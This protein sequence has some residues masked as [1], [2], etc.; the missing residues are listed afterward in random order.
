MNDKKCQFLTIFWDLDQDIYCCEKDKKHPKL[1]SNREKLCNDC[2]LYE[3]ETIYN[4]IWNTLIENEKTFNRNK[5]LMLKE[6]LIEW[7]K[8]NGGCV[9]IKEDRKKLKTK[10]KII[11]T[12]MTKWGIK[13]QTTVDLKYHNVHS[14]QI[15]ILTKYPNKGD[16]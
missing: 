14:V 16:D 6:E 10:D 2:Q 13:F 11:S 5:K 15:K 4:H 9:L 3:Y 1:L 12:Y 7:L 8:H